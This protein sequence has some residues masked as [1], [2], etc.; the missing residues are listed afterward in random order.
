M[1][2]E[3][4]ALEARIDGFLAAANTYVQ[5]LAGTSRDDP[6]NGADGV[7]LPEAVE[8]YAALRA[9]AER[10]SEM[11]PEQAREGLERFLIDRAAHFKPEFKAGPA[12]LKILAPALGAVRSEVAF[13]LAD[14]G[15][16]A[17]RLTER[18][19]LHLQRSIVVDDAVRAK[20][21]DAFAN[22]EVRCEQLGAIHLL[23]PRDLGVQDRRHCERTDLVL[24][25]GGID[26]TQVESAA[27]ALVLTEWKLVRKPA[28]RDA[29]AE[30]GRRQAGRYSTGSLAS[31]ELASN[32]YVVLV[33]ERH[34]DPIADVREGDV[35]Y[36]HVNIAVDPAS[37]SKSK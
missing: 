4:Q 27:E 36:R 15:A 6:Y 8:I 2:T 31:V 9:F 30:Q 35:T 28:E 37:P 5:T 33:S 1:R 24:A 18:A 21:T 11:L 22:G 14:F 13:H 29:Q 26:E 16:A 10:H 12:G 7:L 20:W 19:F 3:W 17:R 32:R 34:L 25:D 23:Y